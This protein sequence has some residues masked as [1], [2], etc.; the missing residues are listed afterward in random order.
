ME[1]KYIV[2]KVGKEHAV[3]NME[4]C[5]I[6]STWKKLEDARFMAYDLNRKR[7]LYEPSISS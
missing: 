4:T 7:D 1:T 6:H 3:I 2:N 5:Q